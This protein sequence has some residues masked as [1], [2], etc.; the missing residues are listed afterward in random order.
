[1]DQKKVG[2]SNAPKET[3][4][5]DS[6]S[7][8]SCYEVYRVDYDKHNQPRYDPVGEPYSTYLAAEDSAMELTAQ[9][10]RFEII[11]VLRRLI[12]SSDSAPP[13]YKT[14]KLN[15]AKVG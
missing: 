1:M 14:F 13:K 7:L 4:V 12:L 9:G 10:Q 5:T 2:L 15:K 6:I 3:L 11:Q 8:H